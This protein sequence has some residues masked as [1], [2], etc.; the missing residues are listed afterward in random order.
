[1]AARDQSAVAGVSVRRDAD[2]W[3]ITKGIILIT[4]GVSLF[5]FMNAAVKLLGARYPAN[6][7]V[8]ARFTGHLIVMLL[9]FLPRYGGRLL[10]TRQ[11]AVQIGRGLLMLIGNALFVVAITHVPLATASA[12]GFTAP[13]IVT[14]LAGPLLREHVGVRRWSA[15]LIGFAGALVIIRP[16]GGLNDP[17]L[18]LLLLG[19]A[20]HA[21]YLIATRWIGNYDSP[22]TSIVFSALMGSLIMTLVLPFSFVWPRDAFDFAMLCSLGLIGAAGHYLVIRA[23]RHGPAAVIAPLSY[24]ELFGTA[25]LGYLIFGNFP[26]LWI[27][28]GAAIIIA[29]GLYIALRERRLRQ[30]AQ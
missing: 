2:P 18:L 8:W 26:D 27:W 11:P 1:M 17:M 20:T 22:A 12:I 6:E 21:L 30:C 4:C 10:A 7:I 3:E 19:S 23:F 5:P 13:L 29:S 24:V 14:A 16:G 25:T 28:V 15:V 9:V